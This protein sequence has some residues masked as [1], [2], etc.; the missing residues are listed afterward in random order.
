MRTLVDGKL[1]AKKIRNELAL[2]TESVKN[3]IS[4]HIVYVG[5]DPVIDNFIKYKKNFGNVLG[6]HV[7]VHRFDEDISEKK[8]VT[9]ITSLTQDA[10]GVIVQLPLP[11][12]L[13]V[14]TVLNTVPADQDVD[15]LGKEALSLFKDAV[16][17]YFPPV[18]GSIAEIIDYHSIDLTDKKI[19][20]VGNGAL[21][22][23]P[24]SLWLES[25][26]YH[27]DL[28]T[29]ET[30]QEYSQKILGNAD[31]VITGAGVPG[32]IQPEMVKEGVVLID[33]G[34]S[35]SGKAVVGDIHPDCIDKAELMT[36]VPGGIGPV[37]IAVLYQNIIRAHRKKHDQ[38]SH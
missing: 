25:S 19:A 30:E 37:T 36:P 1:I 26:G 27:Y 13:D 6:I 3:P 29:K 20:L 15:V 33:A 12:H 18:T 7:V 14:D 31:V 2:Y 16:S 21:V 35:E 22:G 34:T 9:E 5:S 11:E 28:I 23:Y 38:S 32:L 17:N 24:T 4:F 8:L 10:D